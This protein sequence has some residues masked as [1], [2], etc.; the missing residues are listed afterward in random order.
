M[1]KII[2]IISTVLN[3]VI[4]IVGVELVNRMM[5]TYNDPIT[6]GALWIVL[7]CMKCCVDI[8]EKWH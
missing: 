3:I 8:F 4:A 2:K 6:I 5:V 1:N 7:V